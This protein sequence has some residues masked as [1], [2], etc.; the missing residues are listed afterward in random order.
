MLLFPSP[1]EQDS[2]RGSVVTSVHIIVK[3]YK[4]VEENGWYDFETSPL[5]LRSLDVSAILDLIT[6]LR[7]M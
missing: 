5:Y 7:F 2:V 3:L 6:R 4:I 1:A